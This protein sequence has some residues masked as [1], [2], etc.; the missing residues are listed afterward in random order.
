[1]FE[2]DKNVSELYFRD[3]LFRC[4]LCL[5]KFSDEDIGKEKLTIEHVPPESS[6]GVPLVVTCKKCNSRAGHSIDGQYFRKCKLQNEVASVLTKRDAADVHVKIE[7]LSSGVA[8]NA[9]AKSSP[10]NLNFDVTKHNNPS[11]CTQAINSIRSL[12]EHREAIKLKLTFRVS[13]N[14]FQANLSQLRAAYLACFAISGYSYA[15][16]NSTDKLR[17]QFQNPTKKIFSPLFED[18][19]SLEKSIIYVAD[20][21]VFLA[22]FDRR[23]WLLPGVESIRGY[24]DIAN[25][26]LNGEIVKLSGNR[27]P[28]PKRLMAYTDKYYSRQNFSSQKSERPNR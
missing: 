1:M 23:K 18:T 13:Y 4:P 27:L 6:G 26:V 16:S 21:D 28:W 9:I 14:N 20:Y 12:A 2:H 11:N 8:V 7:E 5:E 25:I 10:S 15:T 17:Q 3:K 22:V 24:E 19:E